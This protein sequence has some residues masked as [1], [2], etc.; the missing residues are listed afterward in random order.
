MENFSEG[1]DSTGVVK[2]ARFVSINYMNCKTP[3]IG[4]KVNQS[5]DV[6]AE[7]I[8]VGN[9]KGGTDKTSYIGGKW[10]TQ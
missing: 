2:T 3:T 7:D 6:G 1:D 8:N 10:N 9:V 4:N 5:I